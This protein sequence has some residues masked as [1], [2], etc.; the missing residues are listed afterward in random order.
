M[1][2]HSPTERIEQC[3]CA[4][5]REHQWRH[6]V[7][8]ARL[9]A[10]CLAQS[11]D[12]GN[13]PKRDLHTHIAK[14]PVSAR[15]M[16]PRRLRL[17]CCLCPT[18]RT[19]MDYHEFLSNL[20]VAGWSVPSNSFASKTFGQWQVAFVRMG[21]RFQIAGHITF[22]VC[23]RHTS[24]RDREKELHEV[25]KELNRPGIEL[26]PRSW[27]VTIPPIRRYFSAGTPPG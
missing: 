18:S 23:I 7:L 5:F 1:F 27:T 13:R 24:L 11:G 26:T 6:L 4:V 16:R 3:R 17:Y 8:R 10:N 25:V 20:K 14:L 15:L 22:V 9:V 12:V 2:E 21:G 19:T